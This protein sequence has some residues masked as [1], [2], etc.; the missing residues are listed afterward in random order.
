MGTEMG[1]PEVSNLGA[2]VAPNL[3]SIPE[4]LRSNESTQI[5][6]VGARPSGKVGDVAFFARDGKYQWL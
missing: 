6:T 2:L 1:Y 3:P 5:P 4:N